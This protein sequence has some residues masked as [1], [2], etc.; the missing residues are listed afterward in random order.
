M[1]FLVATFY[2]YNTGSAGGF[3]FC[4]LATALARSCL[5]RK[6][7]RLLNKRPVHIVWGRSKNTVCYGIANRDRPWLYLNDQKCYRV[8]RAS[9]IDMAVPRGMKGRNAPLRRALSV[10][11][12]LIHELVHITEARAGRRFIYRRGGWTI[13]ERC[14][15]HEVYARDRADRDAQYL[16]LTNRALHKRLCKLAK[17]HRGG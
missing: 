6:E 17:K 2:Q 4:S 12:V 5:H 16:L 14:R 8:G 7:W 3:Q 1:S 10:V 11:T 9:L 13:P 15:A